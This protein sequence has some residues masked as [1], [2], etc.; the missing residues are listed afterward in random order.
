MGTVQLDKDENEWAML[1]VGLV[2]SLLNFGVNRRGNGTVVQKLIDKVTPD[3]RHA[4]YRTWAIGMRSEERQRQE[5]LIAGR[6]VW[7]WTLRREV[8]MQYRYRLPILVASS[9]LDFSMP[10]VTPW[11]NLRLCRLILF[12]YLAGFDSSSLRL[13]HRSESV[14]GRTGTMRRLSFKGLDSLVCC[15]RIAD[16][17]TPSLC[18]KLQGSQKPKLKLATLQSHKQLWSSEQSRLW[19]EFFGVAVSIAHR[20][21][22]ASVISPPSGFNPSRRKEGLAMYLL[23]ASPLGWYLAWQGSRLASSSHHKHRSF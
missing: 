7:T 8:A 16:G 19:F 22:P 6:T 17:S 15:A 1:G 18:A 21:S 2:G 20:L 11:G 14:S 10:L 5:R 13:A 23:G 3:R 12:R 4:V 9:Q